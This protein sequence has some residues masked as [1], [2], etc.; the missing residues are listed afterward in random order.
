MATSGDYLN[1]FTS[2]R[3]LHHILNPTNG[4]SP[5]ELSS[6][7]VVAPNACDAD[8]LATALMVMGKPKG[9]ALVSQLEGVEALTITKGGLLEHTAH[10]PI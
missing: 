7:S 10:F 6:V 9:F 1:S 8:A 4:I 3:T 2:D 5:T